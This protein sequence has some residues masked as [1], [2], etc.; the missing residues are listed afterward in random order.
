M[1]LNRALSWIVAHPSISHVLTASVEVIGVMLVMRLLN[2]HDPEF[3]AAALVSAFYY[4]REAGQ[5]EHTLKHRGA[6]PLRAD[7]GAKFLFGWGRANVIQ[8]IAPTLAVLAI[9]LVVRGGIR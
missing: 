3:I 2:F 5:R 8:W 6:A 1:I 7:L 4:G 9:A